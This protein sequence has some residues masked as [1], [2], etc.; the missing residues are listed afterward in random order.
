MARNA[1]KSNWWTYFDLRAEQEFPAFAQGHK[2]AGWITIRN[3][4]NLLNDEWCVLEEVG[5]P[6]N[7]PVVDVSITDDG[8]QY[9]FEEF[10]EPSGQGRVSDP[11]QWEIVLGVTYRF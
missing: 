3:F 11:S 6:R 8:T 7:Q 9:V 4:C 10:V 5:H 2:F 1:F